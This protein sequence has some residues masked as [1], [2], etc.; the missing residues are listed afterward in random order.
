MV[1]T[2]GL[3]MT[4]TV[5]GY[6]VAFGKLGEFRLLTFFKNAFNTETAGSKIYVGIIHDVFANISDS[7]SDSNFFILIFA[8]CCD[9]GFDRIRRQ[10]VELRNG[11]N[12]F[13]WR[14]LSRS[15]L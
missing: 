12:F 3:T 15:R 14:F 2:Y 13:I 9:L 1:I 6:C 11:N 8:I 7:S 5:N 10:A 4:D